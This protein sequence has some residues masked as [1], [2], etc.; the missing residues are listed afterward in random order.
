MGDAS[1]PSLKYHYFHR[2]FTY[3]V[4]L[5]ACGGGFRLAGTT[6]LNQTCNE[7]GSGVPQSVAPTAS[8][9]AS[10]ACVSGG[11]RC[12]VAASVAARSRAF[13]RALARAGAGVTGG[14]AR[15]SALQTPRVIRSEDTF[16]PGV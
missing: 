11:A 1:A 9:P 6:F 13:P 15:G 10:L 14:P 3:S 7:K 5:E 16:R 8:R 2:F 4:K 12:A